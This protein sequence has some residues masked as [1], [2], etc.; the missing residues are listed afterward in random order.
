MCSVV[1]DSLSSFDDKLINIKEY[2]KDVR[3]NCSIL[4]AADCSERP[5]FGVFL[6]LQ[7]SSNTTF[8]SIQVFS[9]GQY[10]TFTPLT[11]D[12][13]QLEYQGECH[14]VT[15]NLLKTH[16]VRDKMK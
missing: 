13:I 4:L 14:V 12:R 16:F 6:F 5:E 2:L 7:V 10:L 15:N 8:Y 3:S 1:K 9:N 11:D